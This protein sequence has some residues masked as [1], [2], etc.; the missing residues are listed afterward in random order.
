[1][2]ISRTGLSCLLPAKGYETFG[3]RLDVYAPSQVPETIGCFCH[4]HPCLPDVTGEMLTAS[5]ATIN[6]AARQLIEAIGEPTAD[7]E[8]QEAALA[9]A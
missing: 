2:R 5:L 6:A 7:A 3:L 9:A 8:L 1:V 4:Y